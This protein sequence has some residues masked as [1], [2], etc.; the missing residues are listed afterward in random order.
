M[1]NKNPIT[2]ARPQKPAKKE[3]SEEVMARFQI[4]EDNNQVSN[5]RR[6]KKLC[7]VNSEEEMLQPEEEEDYAP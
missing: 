2:A 4:E 3:I 7:E 6:L 5:R 1:L